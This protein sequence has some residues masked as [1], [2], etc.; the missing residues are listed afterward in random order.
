MSVM[1]VHCSRESP[2]ELVISTE[3]YTAKYDCEGCLQRKTLL[4]N[5]KKPAVSLCNS[6]A[7]VYLKI[8]AMTLKLCLSPF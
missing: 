7:N 3:L 1:H 2:A 4:K 6:A 8:I 5:G